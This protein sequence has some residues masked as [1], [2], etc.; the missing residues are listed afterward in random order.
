MAR[1][2]RIPNVVA[3]YDVGTVDERV[4][5]AMELVDG[6]DAARVAARSA[7]RAARDR[8]RVRRR[9]ARGLA[10]AHAA[11]LVHRDFKPD[12]VLVGDDGRVR[13]ADFGLARAR[14]GGDADEADVRA[15]APS[16]ARRR[17]RA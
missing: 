2:C 8:R 16:G 6:A 1:I 11:G 7:A 12:N 3:V 5:V 9:P 10:A 4:F 17:A 13:V 14:D 15:V